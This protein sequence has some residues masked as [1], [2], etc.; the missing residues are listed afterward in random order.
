MTKTSGDYEEQYVK[1]KFN[2]DDE[3]HLIKW[4]KSEAW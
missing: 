4:E 3:L 2:L 1:I